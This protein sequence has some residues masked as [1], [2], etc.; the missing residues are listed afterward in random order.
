MNRILGY[1][2]FFLSM[3]ED[4]ALPTSVFQQ[5]TNS[6]VSLFFVV[7]TCL[8]SPDCFY[9]LSL[10]LSLSQCLFMFHI[11]VQVSF[12]LKSLDFLD[13]TI[14]G[15]FFLLLIY[16]Q[17]LLPYSFNFFCPEFQLDAYQIYELYFPFLSHIFSLCHSKLHY[18]Q[19]LHN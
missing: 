7:E 18:G 9:S 2:L 16:F 15:F 3:I 13:L 11:Q 4:T 10:F 12:Y 17:I 8:L 5:M 6:T 14:E 19:V 1:Q